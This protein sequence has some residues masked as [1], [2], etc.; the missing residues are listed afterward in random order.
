[1]A[2][3]T[4]GISKME[5]VRRALQKLGDDASAD[6]I[7]VYLKDH[8]GIGM[9]KDHIY[10]ARGEVRRKAAKGKSTTRRSPRTKMAGPKKAQAQSSGVSKLA[11]VRQALTKLGNDANSLDIQNF[12]KNHHQLEMSRDQITKYKSLLLRKLSKKSGPGRR[13]RRKMSRPQMQAPVEVAAVSKSGNGKSIQLE[14]LQTVKSMVQRVGP[15]HLRSLIDLL[16]E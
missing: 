2:V 8:L 1:M 9:S 12:L 10:V 15:D 13:G 7:Q 6:A 16:E 11:G 5:G 14:D 4:K 3:K